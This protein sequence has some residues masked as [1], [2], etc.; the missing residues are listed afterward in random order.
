MRLIDADLFEKEIKAVAQG[1]ATSLIPDMVELSVETIVETLDEV[2]TAYDVNKVIQTINNKIK[3]LDAKQTV[4]MEYGLF[5]AADAKASQIARYVEC[6]EIVESGGCGE[7]DNDGWI[8]CNERLPE[9]FEPKAYL[10]TNEDGMIGVSYYHPMCGWS[11]GYESVFD[12]IEWQPL[13]EL[14]REEK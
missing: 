12:V 4:F 11:N 1:Q 6:R 10:T 8:P 14:Y 7:I 9:T 5:N 13:P 3:T 2:P